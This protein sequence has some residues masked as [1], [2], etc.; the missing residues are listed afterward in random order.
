VEKCKALLAAVSCGTRDAA[1]FGLD[2]RVHLIDSFFSIVI[3]LFAASYPQC[4]EAT[5]AMT[6]DNPYLRFWVIN[7]IQHCNI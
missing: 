4:R 5:T 6:T 2:A 1:A 3:C 7:G